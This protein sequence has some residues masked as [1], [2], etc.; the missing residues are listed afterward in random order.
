MSLRSSLIKLIT[1]LTVGFLALDVLINLIGNPTVFIFFFILPTLTCF[2]VLNI[3]VI[4]SFIVRDFQSLRRRRV[5]GNIVIDEK[6]LEKLLITPLI[7]DIEEKLTDSEKP[8]ELL[9]RETYGE[10]Y[11][12]KIC[13]LVKLVNLKRECDQG[14]LI[15]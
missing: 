15:I 7:L 3:K 1:G 4:S 13:H 14:P 10:E 8:L 6:Y 5:S 2:I 11:S 9:L 12:S